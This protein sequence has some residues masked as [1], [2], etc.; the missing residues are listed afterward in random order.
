MQ[1]MRISLY[2]LLILLQQYYSAAQDTGADYFNSVF[3]GTSKN[4]FI[5][6]VSGGY[7]KYLQSDLKE[8]N[9]T[10]QSGLNFETTMTDNFPPSLYFGVHLFFRLNKYIA[11][12]PD[13]Q[14][15]TT[16]SRIAYKDY[17]GS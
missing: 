14:F 12:G 9:Q 15:H 1:G 2:F 8:I 13:Y 16:G 7:G 10:V 17:S 11:I 5:F 6:G 3:Q 4:N